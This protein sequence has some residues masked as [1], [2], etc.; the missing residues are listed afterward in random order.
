MKRLIGYAAVLLSFC[1]SSYGANGI[2]VSVSYNAS[3]QSNWGIW[4]GSLV[5]YKISNNSVTSADT[6]HSMANG[7]AYYP[8]I[9]FAGTKV[10]FY[11]WGTPSKIAVW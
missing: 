8:A 6:L 4:C 3:F 2:A 11:R 9:N 10:A 5:R 7:Y 1:V